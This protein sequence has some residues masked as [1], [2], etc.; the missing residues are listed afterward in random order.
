MALGEQG[1][2]VRGGS[3]L[4]KLGYGVGEDGCYGTPTFWCGNEVGLQV[5][6]EEQVICGRVCEGRC[7]EWWEGV[8]VVDHFV[9]TMDLDWST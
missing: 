7:W 2:D 5:R 9:C 1:E 8:L 4:F 6:S 3:C